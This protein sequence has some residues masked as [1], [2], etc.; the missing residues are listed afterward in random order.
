MLSRWRYRW[1]DDLTAETTDKIFQDLVVIMSCDVAVVDPDKLVES[2]SY[3]NSIHDLVVGALKHEKEVLEHEKEVLEQ[4]R[5]QKQGEQSKQTKLDK[6]MRTK[7]AIWPLHR[8]V[9]GLETF[10]LDA[11]HVEA[12]QDSFG[13]TLSF[14]RAM[15][16]GEHAMRNWFHALGVDTH[17]LAHEYQCLQQ[18]HDA[19]KLIGVDTD[20][21]GKTPLS[22]VTRIWG[23]YK[24]GSGG[25]DRHVTSLAMYAPFFRGF[26]Q[27]K[28][29]K[30]FPRVRAGQQEVSVPCAEPQLYGRF[31]QTTEE[32]VPIFRFP[33][34]FTPPRIHL[35]IEIAKCMG[36]LSIGVLLT[37]VHGAGKTSFLDALSTVLPCGYPCDIFHLSDSRA[38]WDDPVRSLDFMSQSSGPL[39]DARASLESLDDDKPGTAPTLSLSESQERLRAIW[40]LGEQHELKQ[41]HMLQ[42]VKEMRIQRWSEE[43]DQLSDP[44]AIAMLWGLLQHFKQDSF[45]DGHS[46]VL[47]LNEVNKLIRRYAPLDGEGPSDEISHSQ[48]G[49][50]YHKSAA[51]TFR[52]YL[53]WETA[54][55][56]RTFRI[57][58]SSP[59]GMREKVHDMSFE[60]FFELRPT[61]S[62]HLASILAVCPEFLLPFCTPQQAKSALQLPL[63]SSDIRGS[64][65]M[66]LLE[67][68]QTLC[69]NMRY[70]NRYLTSRL[71]E[72]ESAGPQS[73]DAA[74][75]K[76]KRS[77]ITVL[78]R[79]LKDHKDLK[80]LKRGESRAN[81]LDM[82]GPTLSMSDLLMLNAS[83][84][85]RPEATD[86]YGQPRLVGLTI[87]AALRHFLATSNLE[88]EV[89]SSLAGLLLH[90]KS[91][92]TAS[93]Q[94]LE[95]EVASRLVL[96]ALS[97]RAWLL[98]DIGKF[99]RSLKWPRTG[100]DGDIAVTLVGDTLPGSQASLKVL[101][102]VE[103]DSNRGSGHLR[104]V[105]RVQ[106][107][108]PGE[109]SGLTGL[110]EL[111]RTLGFVTPATTTS[112]ESESDSLQL[113]FLRASAQHND[114]LW[115]SHQAVANQLT[116]SMGAV[117]VVNSSVAGSINYIDASV[118]AAI[119]NCRPNDSVLIQTSRQHPGVDFIL[120]KRTEGRARVVFIEST[121]ST[122]S[123]HAKSQK[124]HAGELPQQFG[125]IMALM[126]TKRHIYQAQPAARPAVDDEPGWYFTSSS[127]P[128]K[129][130]WT[131]L[132]DESLANFWL[133]VLGCPGRI[134]STILPEPDSSNLPEPDSHKPTLQLRF[135]IPQ[136]PQQASDDSIEWDVSVLYVGCAPD[137]FQAYESYRQLDCDFV[138]CV[139]AQDM[140]D[141][142]DA[143]IVQDPKVPTGFIA[144]PHN[145]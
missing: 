90:S 118:A 31:P 124:Q 120:F 102:S 39:V 9:G 29:T 81:K 91:D 68:C 3:G 30:K 82:F 125:D 111:H 5:K 52:N 83:M 64:H 56:G 138:Y 11:S 35:A 119:Q 14:S 71:A 74:L 131:Q 51:A 94:A 103:T 78:S 100:D 76:A 27:G 135:T 26:V 16:G 67:A 37:G 123:D 22:G 53:P 36:H 33:L 62:D 46:Q 106:F 134:V 140:D 47:I 7:N 59:D 84:T 65:L 40:K 96:S 113:S 61:R 132:P 20:V 112:K 15:H 73:H 54:P 116:A 99:S 142:R 143:W 115:Q 24:N 8:I 130:E 128:P 129:G 127:E 69:G 122:L 49:E 23:V 75:A 97:P 136:T 55:T 72:S 89:R 48:Y 98:S 126:H 79:R 13:W 34:V 93:G 10:G 133:Q 85:V 108:L 77:F 70:I 38:L 88:A 32:M 4:L 92:F 17:K 137:Q 18:D 19:D 43:N 25:T 95:D 110:I 66:P 6:L 45:T 121:I 50:L 42:L 41:S 144:A 58:A 105:G 80:F 2:L 86:P 57:F 139:T 1:T 107:H 104:K 109:V 44:A 117:R 60:P 114:M 28:D 87:I 21:A 12:L 145:Q 101:T 141:A 63:N